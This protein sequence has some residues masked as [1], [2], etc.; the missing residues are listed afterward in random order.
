MIRDCQRS[1]AS[2][3][4]GFFAGQSMLPGPHQKRPESSTTN[5]IERKQKCCKMNKG[6]LYSPAHNGGCRRVPLAQQ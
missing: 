3:R 1:P 2:V 6:S 4:S 5:V